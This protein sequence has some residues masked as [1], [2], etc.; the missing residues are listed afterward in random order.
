M[1][2]AIK[3]RLYPNATQESYVNRLLGCSRKVY[4][5]CLHKK[6]IAYEV[7]QEN[8]NLKDLGKYFHQ[9]LTKSDEYSYLNEHNTKVLKQSI[10]IMLDAYTGFFKH[11]RGFPK[12]KSKHDKQSCRFPLEA[13]SSKNVY[14]DSKITLGSN[15]KNISFECSDRDKLYLNTNRTG[16]RSATLSK[17]KSGRY[18][19]SVLVEGVNNKVMPTAVGTTIGLDLGIKDFVVCSDGVVYDNLKLKRTNEKKLVHLNRLLSKKQKGSKNKN[20]ARLVLAKFHEKLN[21]KKNNYLHNITSK[22]VSENQTIVIE[23]LNVSGMLKNHNLARSIQELS[24]FEFRRQLE[25]KC[26]WYGRE[27]VVIDRWFPSSKLCSGCGAKNKELRL[28]DREWTCGPC[29]THH[30]RDL[31][32]AINIAA[33]GNRII[34]IRCPEYKLVEHPTMDDRLRNQVLKSSGAVKQEVRA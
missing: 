4:N 9:D 12:F 13:I 21:N 2:K 25:Y 26:K 11:G 32:A 17:S 6:K 31:N 27:L 30:D 19:L 15:L 23:D 3:I 34:G 20:K 1:L 5:L 28:S 18:Y 10:M 7:N 24:L 22:L 8:I 29:G 16:V 14:F 33:E